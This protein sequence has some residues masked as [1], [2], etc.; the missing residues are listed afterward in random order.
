[1]TPAP[2]A[3]IEIATKLVS[4]GGKI[5]GSRVFHESMPLKTTDAPGAVAALDATFGKVLEGVV[6]WVAQLPRT[7]EPAK[8][9][10]PSLDDIPEPPA[11]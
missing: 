11:P 2:T 8:K 10:E 9:A 4:A 1:M 3:D 5:E 7:A 6:P